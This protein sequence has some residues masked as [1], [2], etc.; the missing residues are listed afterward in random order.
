MT[1]SSNV[2]SKIK[3][4]RGSSTLVRLDLYELGYA[5]D[6]NKLYIGTPDGPRVVSGE[7][8]Q[9]LLDHI[10]T[11]GEPELV[12]PESVREAIQDIVSIVNNHLSFGLQIPE[13]P[14]V[15]QTLYVLY[16]VL[17]VHMNESEVPI[18]LDSSRSTKD[19]IN[20][21]IGAI[22]AHITIN[23]HGGDH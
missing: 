23:E 7:V 18:V 19:H 2:F 8:P 11:E 9:K 20:Y 13:L 15:S 1:N 6:N 12:T 22:T 3:L 10:V 16:K 4:K 17:M 21:L 5:T 14:S